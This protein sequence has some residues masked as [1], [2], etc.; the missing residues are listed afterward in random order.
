MKFRKS[1]CNYIVKLDKGDEVITELTKFCENKNI[2]AA[3]FTAIGA[4]SKVKLGYFDPV[5]KVYDSKDIVEN[6]EITSLIGNIGRLEN[7][8]EVSFISIRNLFYPQNVY[9]YT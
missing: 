1:G 6:L 8:D 2:R 3:Y 7:D 9:A 4:A 5:T